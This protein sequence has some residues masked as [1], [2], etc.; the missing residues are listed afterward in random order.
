MYI[1]VGYIQVPAPTYLIKS[2]SSQTNHPTLITC[3][4]ISQVPVMG[5][6]IRA[7]CSSIAG[8]GAYTFNHL[9]IGR[10]NRS[11][12]A[13]SNPVLGAWVAKSKA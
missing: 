13:A 6:N 9:D 3:I 7:Q 5:F 4:N 1:N 10:G 8:L 12:V 11:H 2:W